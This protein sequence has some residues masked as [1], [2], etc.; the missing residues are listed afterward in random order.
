[1]P[2]LDGKV[3]KFIHYN[4]ESIRILQS[5]LIIAQLLTNLANRSTAQHTIIEEKIKKENI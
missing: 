5:K 1:M 3:K 4:S 2:V